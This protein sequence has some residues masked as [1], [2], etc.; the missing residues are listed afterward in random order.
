[1]K[2]RSASCVITGAVL[3]LVLGCVMCGA[4][5]RVVAWYP[6]DGNCADAGTRGYDGIPTN[7]SFSSD[8]PEALGEGQSLFFSESFDERYVEIPDVT[9]LAGRYALTCWLKVPAGYTNT[10][11]GRM[12]LANRAASEGVWFWVN[13]WNHDTRSIHA[14][15]RT[16]EGVS[17]EANT[18]HGIVPYGEW[19]H[20]ALNCHGS[21]V[22]FYLNGREVSTAPVQ[23]GYPFDHAWRIGGS[24]QANP[25]CWTGWMDD[26]ALWNDVLPSNL[27]YRLAYNTASPADHLHPWWDEL[28]RMGEFHR[29]YQATNANASAA[30]TTGGSDPMWGSFALRTA[31][32]RCE[33]G[34]GWEA[35][36]DTE[37]RRIG[38]IEAFGTSHGYHAEVRTNEFGEWIKREDDPECTRIFRNSWAWNGYEPEGEVVW[39]GAPNYFE[40][41]DFARPYTRIHPEYGTD[42]IVRYPDGTVATG[43]LD[44]V[45]SWHTGPEDPR[46]LRFYD[47]TCA[48]SVNSNRAITGYTSSTNVIPYAWDDEGRLKPGYLPDPDDPTNSVALTV[49]V[50]K[51]PMCPTWEVYL[52]G[53]L[54]QLLDEGFDGLWVD[55]WSSFDFFGSKPI[56]KAFGEWS[57]A[58]FRD[59]LAEHFSAGELNAM[60]VA[61]VESFDIRGWL[62]ETC[63]SFGGNP[64]NES[65]RTWRDAR[66]RDEKL[67]RVYK[68]Y[69]RQEAGA[70]LDRAYHLIKDIANEYG[71]PDFWI[72][73]NDLQINMG[74]ARTELDTAFPELTWT[75]GLATGGMH[76]GLGFRPPPYGSYV[77]HHKMGLAH[78]RSRKFYVWYYMPVYYD[79]NDEPLPKTDNMADILHYQGLAHNTL[80]RVQPDSA[81][82][83]GTEAEVR[84][85][86][87]FCEAV[88]DIH[89]ARAPVEQVGL[90]FSSS[91]QLL[92]ILPGNMHDNGQPHMFAH[93]GWGTALDWNRYHYRV[94]PEWKLTEENLGD[95]TV[96][97]VPNVEVFDPSRVSELTAWV[98]D[99]GNLIVTGPSGQRRGES[100]WFETMADLSLASLTGVSDYGSAPEERLTAVGAGQVL[101]LKDTI[102]YDFFCAT[103]SRPSMLD[104][105]RDAIG[106]FGLGDDFPVVQDAVDEPFTLGISVHHDM[107][108][109]RYFIDLYNTDIDVDTDVITPTEPASFKVRL[110][111]WL[112]EEPL[113]V[114]AY[115]PDGSVDLDVAQASG[116]RVEISIGSFERYISIV[117]TSARST[118]NVKLDDWLD[119][120]YGAA[121]TNYL[122]WAA[123]DT[124]G[125]GFTAEQEYAAGTDPRNSSSRLRMRSAPDADGDGFRIRWTSEGGRYYAVEK[126]TRLEAGFTQ[127][128]AA[129][130]AATPPSNSV[131]D[132][133]VDA[134]AGFYRVRVVDP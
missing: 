114:Q 81:K 42:H 105:F 70:A 125:D 58:L 1:M 103:E 16:V 33:N 79:E 40:D 29:F 50:L 47:A 120:H 27:V 99:G 53:C 26:V 61:D 134:R 131:I 132:A 98:E 107:P 10:A 93:W 24:F 84:A 49:H 32:L 54:R 78:S 128:L 73:G 67:W 19:M 109:R 25:T 106:R 21:N 57:V 46:L 124:D 30:M 69:L 97:I 112:A 31:F 4:S 111:A 116:D 15:S 64:V 35:I 6:F 119:R 123:G 8:V 63:R 94:V 100:G 82:V 80:P 91:D 34:L 51:D 45:E 88:E 83:A 18:P 60:G 23:P 2:T 89:G 130:M 13:A 115:T 62:R 86:F 44:T 76:E 55:N 56:N 66:W 101:F 52:D 77:P 96:L 28:L 20:V 126:A 43:Y 90:F 102:G 48:K 75:F 36:A 129:R 87:D 59:Y 41:D 68:I 104:S 39:I 122:Q 127:T 85:F 133:D 37:M 3:A 95:L 38:W 108:E 5:P 113:S 11:G 7:V 12:I 14:G 71:K 72:A 118:G 9:E 65:D 92:N 110:P 121:C 17:G 117:L 22:T 74:F